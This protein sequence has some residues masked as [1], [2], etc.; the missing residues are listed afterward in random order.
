MNKPE[1]LLPGTDAIA[2]GTLEMSPYRGRWL[3]RYKNLSGY[4]AQRQFERTAEARMF[5]DECLEK[6]RAEV[7]SALPPPERGSDP[8][9]GRSQK[10]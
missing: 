3:V 5:F 4:V 10:G 8:S 9:D 6:L 7:R 1:L 2:R